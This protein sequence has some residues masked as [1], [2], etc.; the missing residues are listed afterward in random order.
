[1]NRF[2]LDGHRLYLQQMFLIMKSFNDMLAVKPSSFLQTKVVTSMKDGHGMY[3]RAS[4]SVGKSL[5]KP[6]LDMVD[7]YA[8]DSLK[9]VVLSATANVLKSTLVEKD[10]HTAE[11]VHSY[12]RRRTGNT[13]KAQMKKETG[14][15]GMYPLELAMYVW[16]DDY[17]PSPVKQRSSAER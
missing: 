3:C 6:K 12:W 15:G 17:A 8:V 5:P 14:N 2:S 11:D 9:G 1:M 7:D 13:V 16:R 10:S 4:S